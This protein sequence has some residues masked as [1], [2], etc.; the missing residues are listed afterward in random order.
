MRIRE[1]GE[2][3]IFTGGLEDGTWI[4]LWCPEP[5][6]EIYVLEARDLDE[7][8]RDLQAERAR[9][10]RSGMTGTA[11]QSRRGEEIVTEHGPGDALERARALIAQRRHRLEA[12]KGG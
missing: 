12:S 11:V 3:E 10:D 9:M 7:V 2:G 5:G 4:G 1:E 8:H 6:M